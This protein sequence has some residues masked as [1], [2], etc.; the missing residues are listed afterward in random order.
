MSTFVPRGNQSI[1]QAVHMKT[2]CEVKDLVWFE[3]QLVALGVCSLYIAWGNHAED[4]L[5][6]PVHLMDRYLQHR[7]TCFHAEA[8]KRASVDCGAAIQHPWCWK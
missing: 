3:T 6:I 8:L 5:Q 1:T 7:S 2:A 4:F